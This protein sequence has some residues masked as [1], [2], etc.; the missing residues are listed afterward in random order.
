MGG[1]STPATCSP[2]MPAGLVM[3]LAVAGELE[4]VVGEQAQGLV[5]QRAIGACQRQQLQVVVLAVAACIAR[6]ARLTA[7]LPE[8]PANEAEQQ[9]PKAFL[10]STGSFCD[11][12]GARLGRMAGPASV[13]TP[14]RT[15]DLWP[16]RGGLAACGV[17]QSRQ[18]IIAQGR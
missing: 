8:G 17:A 2:C 18:H 9:D 14:R 1:N 5:P 11:V 6:P 16:G 7:L 10:P 15:G 12:G 4:L 3:A 13:P